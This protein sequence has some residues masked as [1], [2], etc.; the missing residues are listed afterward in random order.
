MRTPDRLSI[1]L[2]FT[3]V[4]GASLICGIW[5]LC[6]PPPDFDVDK[7]GFNLKPRE[8]RQ[9]FGPTVRELI[10]KMDVQPIEDAIEL[11]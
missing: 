8:A 1:S 10:E 6:S 11:P 2:T 7:G 9:V 3:F 5:W 4:M